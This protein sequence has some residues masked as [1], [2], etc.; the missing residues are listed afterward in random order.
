MVMAISWE[1]KL[2]QECNHI[3]CFAPAVIYVLSSETKRL[4]SHCNSERQC[5][6]YFLENNKIQIRIS[7]RV[8]G[9]KDYCVHQF[10]HLQHPLHYLNI[11]LIIVQGAELATSRSSWQ[12]QSSNGFSDWHR[13]VLLLWWSLYQWSNSNAKLQTIP[14]L[15]MQWCKREFH[16]FTWTKNHIFYL[17]STSP[18]VG[19]YKLLQTI[20]TDKLMV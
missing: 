19:Y 17:S 20:L 8:A 13:N 2:Q 16:D 14:N 9:G 11:E 12:Y 18:L 4:N 7:E 10:C 3:N 1:F 5:K 15:P 6:S